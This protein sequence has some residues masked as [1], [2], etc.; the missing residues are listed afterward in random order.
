MNS[1]WVPSVM[2]G[3]GRRWLEPVTTI[4]RWARSGLE[5]KTDNQFKWGAF[6]KRVQSEDCYF[7]QGVS[8]TPIGQEFSA[9][10]HRYRSIFTNSGLATFG[11]N[12]PTLMLHMNR[13][14]SVGVLNDI[15]PGIRFDVG[16]VERLP[17]FP[18]EDGDQIVETLERAFTLHESHREP[19]VEFRGPGPSPWRYAQ[20]WAQMAVDRPK[21]TPLPAYEA[22]SDREDATAHLSYALGVALGRFS[23]SGD[24]VDP[25][26]ADLSG[27]TKT[28]MLFLDSTLDV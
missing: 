23:L 17:V 28:D 21:S 24:S 12:A 13:A 11:V 15:A 9:R 25:A 14:W 20:D 8:F 2:G 10:L 1:P 6:T 22:Q 7:S 4:I 27:T 26:G 3:K 5:V 16:D 19:S 18:V